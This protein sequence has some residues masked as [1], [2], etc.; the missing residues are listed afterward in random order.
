MNENDKIIWF[1]FSN[2]LQTSLDQPLVEEP[3]NLPPRPKYCCTCAQK[4]HDSETCF[5]R[6]IGTTSVHVTSYRPILVG[7]QRHTQSKPIPNCT[8]LTSDINDFSFNF[9]NDVSNTGNT[10]YARFRR[11]VNLNGDQNRSTT[12]EN[13]IMFVNEKHLHDTSN[14]P[15]EIYDDFDYEDLST[16]DINSSENNSFMTIDN[17]DGELSATNE[18]KIDY[19]D[20]VNVTANN[21]IA[22]LKELDN[23]LKTL[24]D[25]K[26]KLRS[27]QTN[28]NENDNNQNMNA[29]DVTIESEMDNHTDAF[30]SDQRNDVSTSNP[31]PDFIPLTSNKPELYEPVRS[32][33]PVSADSTTTEKSDATIHLT[34][35]HWI[36]LLD[37]NGTEFIQEREKQLNVSIRLEWRNFGK[38]LIVNGL[39]SN[40]KQFHDELKQFFAEHER[41]KPTKP[42]FTSFANC[43]P[44]NRESLI[45]LLRQQFVMLDS[46]ICNNKNIADVHSMFNRIC[47]NSKNPSKANLRQ[48]SKLRKHLNMILFGR[49]GFADGQTH[50]NALQNQLSTLMKDQRNQ[51]DQNYR[52]QIATHLD[53]IFSDME[54]DN[55]RQHILRYE[56]LKKEKSLPPLNIDRK[57]LGLNINIYSNDGNDNTSNN[58][59]YDRPTLLPNASYSAEQSNLRYAQIASGDISINVSP[60]FTSYNNSRVSVRLPM[61][62]FNE[63]SMHDRYGQ[64]MRKFI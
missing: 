18:S 42:K 53:Y 45:K 61:Q 64:N 62:R 10:I 7:S 40:Q 25:L 57:L 63:R 36:Q 23:K 44:K 41:T 14:P 28:E 19:D 52:K 60:P 37:K 11:A 34:A 27:Y 6:P 38:V 56:Q 22:E 5:R 2:Y 15:I 58:M 4:G 17:M 48:M 1:L 46:A 54:H 26:E 21:S 32:P 20:N 30:K 47:H 3:K 31:L 33:S 12:S 49:Y 55:Y 50:L 59:D 51:V 8:I 35:Q 39:A 24:N 43:L 29:S 16:S 9:G 13:E